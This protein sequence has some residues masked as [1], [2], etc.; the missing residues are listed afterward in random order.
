[1]HGAGNEAG[2]NNQPQRGS[3]RD[4]GKIEDASDGQN[5]GQA[6]SDGDGA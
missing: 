4:A 2:A 5:C 6:D 3:E 1:M